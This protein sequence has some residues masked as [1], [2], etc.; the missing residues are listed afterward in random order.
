[1]GLFDSM[2]EIGEVGD[3]VRLTTCLD[4]RCDLP[5]GSTGVIELIDDLGTRYIR[6][7]NGAMRGLRAAAGDRWEV[8]AASFADDGAR[9]ER[10]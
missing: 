10:P 8:V 5:A 7:D 2:F 4:P 9:P 3:R 1:M 6:W